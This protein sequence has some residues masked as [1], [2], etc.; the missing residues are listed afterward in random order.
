MSAPFGH[1]FI[2]FWGPNCVRL[3]NASRV[4]WC[5]KQRNKSSRWWDIWNTSLVVNNNIDIHLNRR[6][7][8][9]TKTSRKIKQET[10]NAC[11]NT[12]NAQTA[13]SAHLE[14]PSQP[15]CEEARDLIQPINFASW[16]RVHLE[17]N[18]T[19][20][21]VQRWWNWRNQPFFLWKLSNINGW[22]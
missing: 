2:Q 17:N 20:T 7:Q 13:S 9:I 3:Q 10:T 12:G 22:K 21:K 16:K 5:L 15:A 11:T 4:R 1:V 19:K 6:Q 18:H 8:K 14:T